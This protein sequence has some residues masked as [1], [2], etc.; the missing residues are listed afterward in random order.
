[1]AGQNSDGDGASVAERRRVAREA[2]QREKTRRGQLIAVVSSVVVIGGLIALAV[3]SPGWPRFEQT[4]LS[5]DEFQNSFP[6]IFRG[7]W[8]D[9]KMF[10]VIEVAVLL[11][12]LVFALIRTSSL[13]ALFPLRLLAAAYTDVFR[14]VPTILLVFMVG[15]G[16]PAL[17]L[18]GV[19]TN[20]VLLGG[21]AL[22]LSYSAYV[23]EVYR[24]GIA[25][26]HRSQRDAALAIGLTE[27][28]SM[29]L[30]VL[31]QAVR[32]VGPPLLNDFI[33]LQKDVALVSVLG[34]LEAY[35]VAQIFA[36][37]NF[38]YTPFVA[39]ALLYLCV[40]I[41]LARIVDRFGSGGAA[42]S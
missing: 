39:A 14:G 1:M 35:R 6:D 36:G 7:F 19:P 16:I 28:Q 4:F 12:G 21:F 33:S 5:W 18:S 38:N 23:S 26:I 2:A 34:V 13:P 31:P 29:R 9:V 32:R 17:E 41:P 24:A 15:F 30:V 3:T 40:T 10:V 25:S 22:T 11:V 42:R 20:P 37:E 27:S 8:L